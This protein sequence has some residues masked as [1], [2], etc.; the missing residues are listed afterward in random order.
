MF[1]VLFRFQFDFGVSARTPWCSRCCGVLVSLSITSGSGRIASI[2][3]TSPILP[4]HS[5]D[6][7][8]GDMNYE[9]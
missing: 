9:L 4:F 3:I 2:E 7:E 8:K 5:I 6:S 1:L